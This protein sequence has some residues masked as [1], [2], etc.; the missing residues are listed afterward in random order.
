MVYTVMSASGQVVICTVTNA[1][2]QHFQLCS[3][4]RADQCNYDVLLM[5]CDGFS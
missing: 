1:Y 5:L 2:W 4:Q 3:D